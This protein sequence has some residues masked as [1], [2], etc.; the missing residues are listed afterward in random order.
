EDTESGQIKGAH[1][2]SEE[3]V[4]MI[5]YV[6]ILMKANLTLAELQS[7]IFAYPSPASDLTA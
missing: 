7:D 5:N 4:Y 3:A 1:F 2:L 6:A